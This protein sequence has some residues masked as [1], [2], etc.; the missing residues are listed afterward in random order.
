MDFLLA[1]V[2]DSLLLGLVSA[3]VAVALLWSSP[4]GVRFAC[5]AVAS[6]AL[7]P[8]ANREAVR[9]VDGWRS[10]VQALGDVDK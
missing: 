1:A 4:F 2:I 8:L 5:V 3:A 9:N 7:A 10:A 6:T